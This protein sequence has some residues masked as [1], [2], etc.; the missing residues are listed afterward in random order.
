MADNSTQ[1]G[2]DT[3]RD[4][5]RAGVKTEIVG[6]DIGIGTATEALLSQTNP[7]PVAGS[8]LATQSMTV[9]AN[10]PATGSALAVS[11]AGNVTFIVKN[12]IAGTAYTGVPVI[13]F[14]QS[15]DG[16]SW[17]PLMVTSVLGVASTAPIIATGATS[18][19]Q[20]FD[21]AIESVNWVRVRVVTAQ[22]AN[23]MI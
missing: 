2:T 5:D 19:E 11:I 8:A 4:K 13:V 20:M 3:I 21:A 7:M 9:S 17:C 6:L 14:E 10:T 22:T 23:G 1:G 15:D 12:S 18:T 16:V